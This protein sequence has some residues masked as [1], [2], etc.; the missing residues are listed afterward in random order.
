MRTPSP[1][2]ETEYKHDRRAH[3]HRCKGC[4]KILNAGERVIMCKVRAGSVAAHIA[5]ADRPHGST[6]TGWTLRDAFEAWGT[7]HL[8]ARG[9]KLPAHPMSFSGAVKGAQ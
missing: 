7:D 3:R 5:C 4:G 8:I 9:F 6:E 1:A 2:W